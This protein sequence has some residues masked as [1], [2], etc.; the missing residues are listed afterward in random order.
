MAGAY[1]LGAVLA[2]L[3][4]KLFA[5]K[6]R[7]LDVGVHSTATV[8]TSATATAQMAD[9]ASAQPAVEQN[10]ARHA[11]T[12]T[13]T[14]AIS[15]SDSLSARNEQM[16]EPAPQRVP[17]TTA[18]ISKPGRSMAGELASSDR[19]SRFERSLSDGGTVSHETTT[20]STTTHTQTGVS[21]TAVAASVAA[22][23]VAAVAVG[24]HQSDSVEAVEHRGRECRG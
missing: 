1:I 19:V 8:A 17:V 12:H 23:A 7:A 2:C 6:R 10:V 3:L 21:A 13:S 16:V 4:R 24:S 11:T 18:E 15:T 22:A 9:T 14:T 5:P 20:T